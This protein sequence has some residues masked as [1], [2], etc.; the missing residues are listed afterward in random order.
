M[1]DN[2]VLTRNEIAFSY[3]Q[4]MQELASEISAA[5]NAIATNSSSAFQASVAKQELLCTSLGKMAGV[6]SGVAGTPERPTDALNQDLE[7]RL[8]K[9]NKDMSELN[10]RYAALLNHSGKSI[11]LLVSLCKN[12]TGLFMQEAHGIRQKHQTWSCEV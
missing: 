12:H 1:N 8:S 9:A 6:V 10:Q 3:L 11:A 2:A 7:V 5:T 4:Q